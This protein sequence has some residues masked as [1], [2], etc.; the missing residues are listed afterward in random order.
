MITNATVKRYTIL[1]GL[2]FYSNCYD[3]QAH[4]RTGRAQN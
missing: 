2:Y 1:S 4:L 3:N